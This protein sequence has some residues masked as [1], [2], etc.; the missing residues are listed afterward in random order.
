MRL[1]VISL[2]ICEAMAML[3]GLRLTAQ[4]AGAQTIDVDPHPSTMQVEESSGGFIA[5]NDHETLEVTICGNALVHVV[6]RPVGAQAT[7]SP[8]PWMLDQAQSC[9]GAQFQFTQSG[10]TER[11]VYLPSGDDKTVS[12]SGEATTLKF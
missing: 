4:T 2:I 11:S 5:R 8:R 10:A 3:A 7:S 12:Y 1:N 6:G 9:P